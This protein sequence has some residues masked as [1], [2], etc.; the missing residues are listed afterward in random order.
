[1]VDDG[2]ASTGVAQLV[3]DRMLDKEEASMDVK[4]KEGMLLE[5]RDLIQKGYGEAGRSVS[6][7]QSTVA[8]LFIQTSKFD[9]DIVIYSIS[10]GHAPFV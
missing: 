6:V 3:L 1:M 5:I 7:K 8:I 10:T 4:F 2:D 9:P